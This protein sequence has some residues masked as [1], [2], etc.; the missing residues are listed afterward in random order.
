MREEDLVL[1][2]EVVEEVRVDTP[3]AAAISATVVSSYPLSSNSRMAA[4]L[5]RDLL[6]QVVDLSSD[7]RE[8]LLS[9][10]DLVGERHLLL[11]GRLSSLRRLGMRLPGFGSRL[12]EGG[13][14]QH[15]DLGQGLLVLCGERLGPFRGRPGD[16]LCFPCSGIG[17]GGGSQGFFRCGSGLAYVK[18]CGPEYAVGV[19]DRPGQWCAYS[20]GSD[21][22][23]RRGTI[24][25]WL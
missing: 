22:L 13:C 11:G 7:R 25:V 17:L 15:S 9:D 23:H 20:A 2:G 4:L 19:P 10:V 5:G 14:F 3:A 16:P 21:H 8:V 24:L 6:G 12:V 18:D 1:A